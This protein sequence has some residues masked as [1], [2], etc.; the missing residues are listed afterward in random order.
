M[1]VRQ[2]T[3][4][5]A[6]VVGIDG[7]EHSM[8]ALRRALELADLLDT[9]LHVVHVTD[10]TPAT[11]HLAGGITVNTTELAEVQREQVWETAAEVLDATSVHVKRVNLNGYPSDELIEHTKAV[12]ASL[13]VL[14]TRGRGKLSSTFLGSTSLRSLERATCDVLIAKDRTTAD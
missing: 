11:V 9:D 2:S 7:S 13:L 4:N 12:E 14:G 10:V 5:G 6:V 8:V 1:N 3:T